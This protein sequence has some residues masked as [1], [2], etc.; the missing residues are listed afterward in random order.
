MRAVVDVEEG[1]QNRLIITEI[2]Y[3]VNK[4]DLITKIAN[5]VKNKV[6]DGISNIRD[7]S[8]KKGIRVVIDLKR[9]EIPNVILNQL[10]KHTPLQSKMS[11]LLLALYQNRPMIFTLREVLEHFILHRRE[12]VTRRTEFDL[13][14]HEARAHICK[15]LIVALDNIDKVVELIKKSESAEVA[16]EGLK[17]KFKLSDAQC[18][19]ILEMRL[20]RLT[21]LE[22]TKLHDELKLHQEFI[23]KLRLILDDASVLDK[24]IIKEFAGLHEITIQCSIQGIDNFFGSC[25]C[26]G[27]ENHIGIHVVTGSG[28]DL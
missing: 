15:G 3:Q 16:S 17:K 13:N 7:E 27:P 6:V 18:K 8:N 26:R 1:K 25:R 5:L 12:I 22:Q 28:C 9:G 10:Y 2:P 24:E 4:S 11:I 14:K 21:G 20:Q 23:T 19:A